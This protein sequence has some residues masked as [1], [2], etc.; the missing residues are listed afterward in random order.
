MRLQKSGLV[1]LMPYQL[2]TDT[3]DNTKHNLFQMHF[4]PFPLHSLV[5]QLP[6]ISSSFSFLDISLP[7]SQQQ[8]VEIEKWAG[9]SWSAVRRILF[10]FLEAKRV[11]ENSWHLVNFFCILLRSGQIVSL[12]PPR[13]SGHGFGLSVLSTLFFHSVPPGFCLLVYFLLCD[14]AGFL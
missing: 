5:Q 14:I 4:F 7:P 9:P 2:L 1:S 3:F 10:L 13:M 8:Q 6:H 11:R 12:L